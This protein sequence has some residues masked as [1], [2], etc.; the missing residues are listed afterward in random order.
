[1]I[2][3]CSTLSWFGTSAASN[4]ATL[5]SQSV[6]PGAGT[7]SVPMSSKM[8]LNIPSSNGTL[9]PFIQPQTGVSQPEK[10]RQ[11][12]VGNQLNLMA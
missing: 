5:R 10:P 7:Q 8:E 6:K 1:M 12:G 4:A 3:S 11:A 9:M 2:T